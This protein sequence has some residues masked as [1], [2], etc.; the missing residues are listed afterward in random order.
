LKENGHEVVVID[1]INYRV[2]T[3]APSKY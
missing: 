2:H 3:E 1:I